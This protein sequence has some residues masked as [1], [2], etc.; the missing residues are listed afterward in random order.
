MPFSRVTKLKPYIWKAVIISPSIMVS[1]TS[2]LPLLFILSRAC[3]QICTT[4]QPVF[5]LPLDPTSIAFASTIILTSSVDCKGCSLVFST[6]RAIISIPVP[7]PTTTST[8]PVT[9]ST[10]YVC[11]AE[12]ST[13]TSTSSFSLGSTI[14]PTASPLPPVSSTVQS[15]IDDLFTAILYAELLS[16]EGFSAK[17]CSVISPSGLDEIS[18]IAIN[19]TALQSQVCAL[20]AIDFDS[21]DLSAPV[22]ALNQKG[23]SLLATALFAVQVA[24]NYAGG[25]NLAT[26][27]SEIEATLID[28]PF[29]NYISNKVGTEVK[30]YVCSAATASA[31]ASSI[32]LPTASTAPYP[33]N[34]T[35]STTTCTS[36][37]GFANTVVPAPPSIASSFAVSPTFTAPHTLFI[38]NAIDVRLSEEAVA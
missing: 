32:S 27:C 3:A 8:E 25:P 13:T 19:G 26:L 4:L 16:N 36:P 17:L 14:T 33:K 6:F 7:T 24:G 18:G 30:K 37:L 22:I 12:T 1:V 38:I 9:T 34:T 28:N 20:A 2:L 23:I 29:I 35:N 10:T 11:L 15:F 31:S 5:E 21:P